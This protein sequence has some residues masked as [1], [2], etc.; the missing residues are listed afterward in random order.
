MAA[1]EEDVGC[2]QALIWMFRYLNL[3]PIN[4]YATWYGRRNVALRPTG[5]IFKDI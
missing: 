1:T 4:K 5:N 3:L 2:G